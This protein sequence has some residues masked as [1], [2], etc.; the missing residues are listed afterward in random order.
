LFFIR[1][2]LEKEEEEKKKEREKEKPYLIQKLTSKDLQ[3]GSYPK[4]LPP[5]YTRKQ[6]ICQC[7]ELNAE[8]ITDLFHHIFDKE[9]IDDRITD[10]EDLDPALEKAKRRGGQTNKNNNAIT[11][12]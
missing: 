1:G 10:L 12:V 9:K 8:E 5:V 6:L 11:P 7:E 4:D 3:K 2:E